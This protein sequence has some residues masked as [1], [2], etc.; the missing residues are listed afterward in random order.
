MGMTQIVVEVTHEE[1]A[2]LEEAASARGLRVDA[3]LAELG[4]RAAEGQAAPTV[5]E[6][7]DDVA[8]VRAR[9]AEAGLLME[10]P[11]LRRPPPD[12]ALVEAA[13][14]EAGKGRSLSDLVIEDRR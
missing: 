1:R 13:K 8:R 14:I 3:W 4:L 2:R 10:A 9:F 6:V 12:P 5:D 11:R 7:E